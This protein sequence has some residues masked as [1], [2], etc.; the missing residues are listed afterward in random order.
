[1]PV[2]PVQGANNNTWGT[3]MNAWL[4]AGHNADG[5][6]NMQTR[7]FEF[8]GGAQNQSVALQ[9]TAWN[10]YLSWAST[11]PGGLCG[12][13]PY[14][15]LHLPS[16]INIPSYGGVVGAGFATRLQI[17]STATGH[18]V[19]PHV[20]SNGTTD[21]NGIGC[22]FGH[23]FLDMS[24]VDSA[25]VNASGLR[26]VV[27][28][29]DGV[30]VETN[31]TAAGAT[32]ATSGLTDERFNFNHDSNTVVD[33]VFVWTAPRDGIINI[34]D[35]ENSIINCRVYGVGRYG[36]N[37]T[38]DSFIAFNTVGGS[39]QNGF[40]IQSSSLKLIGN[41]SWYSGQLAGNGSGG[42]GFYIHAISNGMVDGVGNVSQ[43]NQGPGMLIDTCAASINWIG[44]SCDSNSTAAAGGAPAVDIWNSFNAYVQ[45]NCSERISGAPTQLHA[46]RI[47]STSNNNKFILTHKGVNG[48]TVG[49]PIDTNSDFTTCTTNDIEINGSRSRKPATFAA[50]FTPDP[51]QGQIIALTLTGNIT[52]N[53]PIAGTFWP[54]LRM[55]F[56]LTQDATGG[57]TIT[58]SSTYKTP[59]AETTTAN[60][61][62]VAEFVYDGTNWRL[63]TFITGNA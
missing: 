27:G 3:D 25:H 48:A 50:S 40:V 23:F 26:S 61:T 21:P 55:M 56:V 5:S 54:G 14:P 59:L 15:Y 12:F 17:D 10:N 46:L 31:P 30:H 47:R 37:P 49:V 9:T 45:M 41:K 63:I 58:W 34:G 2:L 13:G 51:T 32:L 39:G 24:Q 16:L 38:Y 60:T 4:T 18:G 22:Y 35:G 28:T 43:D 1:M 52:I 29:Q 19:A 20:S 62:T 33:H 53:A 44:G 36:I 7:P 8:F 11:S 57:R 6:H 42:A